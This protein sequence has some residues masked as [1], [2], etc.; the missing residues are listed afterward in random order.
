MERQDIE[1]FL[2]LAEELH[3]ARTAGRAEKTSR[4]ARLRREAPFS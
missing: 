1:V 2:V 3:F 4:S